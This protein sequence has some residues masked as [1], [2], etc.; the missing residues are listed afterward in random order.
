MDNNSLD[1]VCINFMKA[2]PSKDGKGN[3]LVMTDTFSKFG[4]AVITPN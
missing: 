3:V 1:L 2:D 4:L